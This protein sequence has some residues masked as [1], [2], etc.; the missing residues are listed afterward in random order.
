MMQ[1]MLKKESSLSVSLYLSEELREL[2]RL[3]PLHAMTWNSEEDPGRW[4]QVSMH[5][6]DERYLTVT[7]VLPPGAKKSDVDRLVGRVGRRQTQTNNG[8]C[9]VYYLGRC[10]SDLELMMQVDTMASQCATLLGFLWKANTEENIRRIGARGPRIPYRKEELSAISSAEKSAV[11]RLIM[12]AHFD[13]E[14][15]L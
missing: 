7:C 12:P 9:L 8:L 6:G 4:I 14:K 2:I 15:E 3:G 1:G 11:A 5:S 13:I 10:E